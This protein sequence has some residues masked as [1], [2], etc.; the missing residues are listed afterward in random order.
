MACP[1]PR[2]ACGRRGRLDRRSFDRDHGALAAIRRGQLGGNWLA[3][4]EA[5]ERRFVWQARIAILLVGGTGF[6]MIEEGALWDRFSSLAYWWMDAM[7]GLWSVFAIGLFL[8]EPLILDRRLRALTIRRPAAT[9]AWLAGVH[10]LLLTL[11]LVTVFG[12]VAGSHGWLIFSF[13][14]LATKVGDCGLGQRR[15]SVCGRKP[16]TTYTAGSGR[17]LEDPVSNVLKWVLLIVASP[18]SAV[19]LGDRADLRTGAPQPD[20]F[21]AAGGDAD[22]GRRHRRR[23]GRLPE[24]RPDGLREPLRDGLLFRQ[25]YTAFALVRLA[26]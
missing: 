13:P 21:V 18:V 8:V 5:I 2:P 11:S 6:Y 9:F 12:A 17:P 20:R 7:V 14:F 10:W 15:V 26:N 16:M 22:D 4:F 19:R 25:D 3:A 23:Q 1:R 24:S